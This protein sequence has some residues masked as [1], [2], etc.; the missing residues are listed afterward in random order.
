MAEQDTEETPVEPETE[1]AEEETAEAEAPVEEDLET[2]L[3][4]ER[5]EYYDLLLR[6]QAELQN[7]RKRVSR[8]KDELRVLARSELIRELLLVM[9]ACEKGLETL[10][11]Q[12]SGTELDS[13]REGFELV[14]RQLGT[15]LERNGVHS[16]PGVGSAFDP[17][18][19]EA[20]AREA[21]GEHDEGAIIEEFRKG[22]R[23][24]ERLLR[25]SQVKV[26]ILDEVGEGEGE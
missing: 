11:G 24:G 22:Y 19:H 9:D 25:P 3:R 12:T 18:Y 20:V 10:E 23:I 8:E 13:Y 16:V 17:R 1:S 7:Y 26:A 6:S 4:R 21:G 15:L 5:D 14:V 2:R